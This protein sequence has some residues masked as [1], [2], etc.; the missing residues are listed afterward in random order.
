MEWIKSRL[1]ADAAQWH[2]LWSVR[3]AL[4]WGAFSGLWVAW[5]AFQGFMPPLYFAGSCIA[6]SL[7]ITVARLTNQPGLT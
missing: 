7:A 4:F 3:I 5:P 1:D 2:K 6:F